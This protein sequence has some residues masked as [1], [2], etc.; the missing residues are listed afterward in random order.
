MKLLLTFII[1]NIANVIIQTIKSISTIKSGKLVASLV[2]ATAYG[3][4]TVV[5][6]YM[7]VDLE[8]WQ[9]V[10]VVAS[11]NLVGVYVVK[12]IEEKKEKAMLWK[13]EL[14][15]AGK[16]TEPLHTDLEKVD[17][18]HN[19]IEN[20]G[21]WTIFNCFCKT[22]EESK[23]IKDIASKYRAKYFVSETKVL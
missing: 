3:L 10:L 7:N 12:L 4:Y 13:I 21:E 16:F 23:I 8:L 14:T 18:S 19:Y 20:I 1:L 17:L 5:L 9:K 11:A 22:Q 6:I 15:V 2:N